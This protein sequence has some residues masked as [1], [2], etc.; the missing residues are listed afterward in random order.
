MILSSTFSRYEALNIR[1]LSPL[2]LPCLLPFTFVITWMIS[3][4]YGWKKYS[5]ISMIVLLFVVIN[6]YQYK[7]N[8]ELYEMAN[9]GGI[10][11]YAEDSWKESPILNYINQ[12]KVRFKENP[13]IF[14]DGNE[15]VYLFT[16]LTADLVPHVESE[17]DNA[18][19]VE[20][21]QH[22]YYLVWFYDNED[23][24]L[25]S[26]NKMLKEHKYIQLA[27]FPEGCIYYHPAP[28]NNQSLK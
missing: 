22:E 3:K 8:I 10:P 16:G 5:L 18:D 15:A 14:S 4:Q 23:P 26:L 9:N 1:L 11:G 27:S 6:Y 28:I 25:L 7:D 17:S 12:N 20:E 24:E 19:F 2:Y 13:R 21:Q